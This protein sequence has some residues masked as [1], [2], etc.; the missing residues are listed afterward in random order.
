[1]FLA[2]LSHCFMLWLVNIRRASSTIAS[3]GISEI[4]GWVLPNLAEMVFIGHS[5]LIVPFHCISRSHR[6]KID[7]SDETTRHR[8]LIFAILHHLVDLFKVCANYAPGARN[9]PVLGS[10]V[11]H[12]H[13]HVQGKHEKILS[14]TTRPRTTN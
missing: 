14:E 3:K 8:A 9:G 5:L 7:F 12:R 13:I 10:H 2:H 1:M 11:L 4:T 6:L